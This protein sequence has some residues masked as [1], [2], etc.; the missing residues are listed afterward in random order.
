MPHAQDVHVAVRQQ[1]IHNHIWPKRDELTA[2]HEGTTPSTARKD[3][4]AIAREQDF[5]GNAYSGNWVF[6]CNIPCNAGDIVDGLRRPANR[7]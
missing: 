1:A 6:D 2:A 4:Q 3:L 5:L 7:H